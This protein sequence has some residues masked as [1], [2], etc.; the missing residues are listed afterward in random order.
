MPKNTLTIQQRKVKCDTAFPSC[1]QCANHD[2]ECTYSR[3]AKKRG[4]KQGRNSSNAKSGSGASAVVDPVFGNPKAGGSSPSRRP[5]SAATAAVTKRRRVGSSGDD[6]HDDD[7]D[8]ADDDDVDLEQEQQQK[9]QRQPRQQRQQRQKRP[10]QPKRTTTPPSSSS[11]SS[12]QEDFASKLVIKVPPNSTTSSGQSS[13]FGLGRSYKRSY[14]TADTSAMVVTRSR[15]DRDFDRLM[16][17]SSTKDDVSSDEDDDLLDDEEED[18]DE[19]SIIIEH[20]G[21]HPDGYVTLSD[22]HNPFMIAFDAAGAVGVEADHSFGEDRTFRPDSVFFREQQQQQQQQQRRQP[23]VSHHPSP[24]EETLSPPSTLFP[25][26]PPESSL[27]IPVDIADL[28]SPPQPFRPRTP[29]SSFGDFVTG[30]DKWHVGADVVEE[31]IDLFF[32]Y[33]NPTVGH[34]VHEGWFRALERGSRDGVVVAAMCAVASRYVGGGEG[35]ERFL[36]GDGFYVQAREMVGKRMDAPSL[37]MVSALIMLVTYT[38]GSGRAAAS[39]MYS[40]LAIR[41]AQSLKLDLDPDF[42][43]IETL[44][45]ALTPLEKERRRR[46]WWCCFIMD[47]YTASAADR[48]FL[49]RERDAVRVFRPVPLWEWKGMGVGRGDGDAVKKGVGELRRLVEAGL[50]ADGFGEGV[51][52]GVGWVGGVECGGCAFGHYIELVRIFGRV[53]EYVSLLKAPSPGFPEISLVDLPGP[54]RKRIAIERDL[55]HWMASLPEGL[56]NPVA[57]DWETAKPFLPHLGAK[58]GDKVRFGSNWSRVGREGVL[59][60]SP[61]EVAFL[62]IL[63]ATAI[64]LLNRPRMM[65]GLQTASASF[66]GFFGDSLEAAERCT[67]ILEE[68]GLVH[69]VGGV[70]RGGGGGGRVLVHLEALRAFGRF[71]V[72]GKRLFGLLE[73]LVAGGEVGEV[74]VEGESGEEGV[75]DEVFERFLEGGGAVGGGVVVEG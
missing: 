4:P 34:C 51:G 8:H 37:E 42:P 63:H 60:P 30:A 13:L 59:E 33:V 52:E 1:K 6:D 40:G 47:R 61:W 32:L 73:G 41:M 50:V 45:G 43:E 23:F 55:R 57:V 49:V 11:S 26:F 5:R 9:Q 29:S 74:G 22:V 28:L 31:L 18:E 20:V 44:F 21:A 25:S 69:V 62:H 10:R 71:W 64:V 53:M 38:S 46:L 70:R 19:Q 54:E 72:Q 16:G 56:R 17:S 2:L 48:A 15:T 27:A 3:E 12:S 36:M 68:C 65:A 58:T 7:D 66:D 35:Q 24:V 14:A 39:W 75:G 67:R